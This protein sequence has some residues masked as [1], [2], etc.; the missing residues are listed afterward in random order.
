MDNEFEKLL[1]N[2]PPMFGRTELKNLLPGVISGG[3]L[4]NLDSLGT[5][6][7]SKL[8]GRRRVYFRE[9]FVLWLANR[10]KPLAGCC[11]TRS[12]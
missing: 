8:V 10:T 5:G 2:L 12:K 6:P 4:A 7:P 11:A 1:K 3:Y 9:S